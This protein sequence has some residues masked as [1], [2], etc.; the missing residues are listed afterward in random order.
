MHEFFLPAAALPRPIG[1]HGD[2]DGNAS[3]GRCGHRTEHTAMTSMG[4]GSHIGT[5]RGH[6]RDRGHPDMTFSMSWSGEQKIKERR[7][8]KFYDVYQNQIQMDPETLRTSFM[9]VP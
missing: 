1:Y 2:R 6:G 9:D 8:H 5:E 3:G 4:S 7:L